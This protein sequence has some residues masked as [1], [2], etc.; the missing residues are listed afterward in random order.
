MGAVLEGDVQ[1]SHLRKDNKRRGFK[2][3]CGK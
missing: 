3:V 1:F 2:V